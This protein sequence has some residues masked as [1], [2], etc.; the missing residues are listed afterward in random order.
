MRRHKPTE[1]QMPLPGVLT[2]DGGEDQIELRNNRIPH[3]RI[4]A[5]IH[6]SA[7]GT[8]SIPE[9][10]LTEVLPAPTRT[11]QLLGRKTSANIINGLLGYEVQASYKRIHC[12]DKPTARYL[13]LFTELGCRRILLPYDPTLTEKLL[14]ELEPAFDLLQKSVK[15]L[16]PENPGIQ[17]YVMRKISGRIRKE[18][19]TEKNAPDPAAPDSRA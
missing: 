4:L 16:F 14:A 3:H 1:R 15:S 5:A 17:S 10:Y 2:L 6:A 12:P 9:I 18:L 7:K 8:R 13:K 19:R 11:I